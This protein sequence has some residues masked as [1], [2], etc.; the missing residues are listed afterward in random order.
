LLDLA[1][2]LGLFG[3][4]LRDRFA[5][6]VIAPARLDAVALR[7]VGTSGITVRVGGGRSRGCGCRRS[8]WRARRLAW[9]RSVDVV[10]RALARGDG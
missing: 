5:T 4:G 10:G 9:R 7:A 6:S 3:V 1:T 8:G 2:A